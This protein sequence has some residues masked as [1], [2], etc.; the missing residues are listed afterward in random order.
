ML[1][2]MFMKK[3]VMFL[4]V[5][6]IF[7]SI[8]S[9]THNNVVYGDYYTPQPY[10]SSEWSY[11]SGYDSDVIAFRSEY[12]NN[13]YYSN[14]GRHFYGKDDSVRMRR[15]RYNDNTISRDNVYSRNYLSYYGSDSYSY[16]H[17]SGYYPKSFKSTSRRSY[18]T[19]SYY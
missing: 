9:A 8:A 3:L 6:L 16:S 2:V 12:G 4:F 13:I 15:S 7:A 10:Y 19:R 11:Y 1:L 18:Y 5:F 17:Y 14:D